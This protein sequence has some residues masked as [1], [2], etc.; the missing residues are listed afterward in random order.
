MQ[1]PHCA[2][3]DSIRYGTGVSN[4][5]V[6]KPVDGSCKHYD[7]AKIQPS[8]SRPVSSIWKGWGCE[9]SAGFS[10]SITRRSLAGW[11][12]L[13][14]HSQQAQHRLKPAP[15]SKSMNSAL[16]S[17]KKSQ[18][19]L[20]LAVDSIFGKVLSFAFGRRT[21]KTGKVLWQQIKHLP[22]MGDGTDMLNSYENFIPHAKHYASKTFT[23]QIESLNCRL[24]HYLARL[25]RRTLCYSKPK[26]ML[27]VSLKLLIHKLN[28]P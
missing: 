25:H 28:N 17:L 10:G 6:A 1:C 26:T 15:S 13:P 5:T 12:K 24:R 20:W 18:C 19:W 8:S 27:E 4:A 9:R 23:T 14:S 2:H 16:S 11:S 7:E 21:I 22:T 3:P